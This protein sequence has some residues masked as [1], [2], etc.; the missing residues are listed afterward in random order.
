MG[1]HYHLLL[2][3]PDANLGRG[4]RQLNGVF[5][6]KLNRR[7]DRVG[8]VFQGRYKAILVE[9]ESHLLELARYVVLNPVRAKLVKQ[10]VDWR[11]SSYGA[12]A[13]ERPAPPWLETD[14]LLACFGGRGRRAAYRRFVAEGL[15]SRPPWEDLESG[16]LGGPAFLAEVRERNLVQDPEVP[17]AQRHLARP[18]LA[19]LRRQHPER[20]A[21]MAAACREHGYTMSEIATHAGLH[22]SSVSKIIKAWEQARNSQFKT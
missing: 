17:R 8:H 22:Y 20:A 3:T 19:D 6:Q 13:G 21:W 14:W 12:T 2:E 1:N 16:V 5:T 15:G 7:H 11:W 18:S 10:V 9:K 4:M